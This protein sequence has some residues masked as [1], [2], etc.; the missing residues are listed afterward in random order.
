M[1]I[2]GTGEFPPQDAVWNTATKYR[3]N[4][5]YPKDITMT[6]AGVIQILRVAR[7]DWH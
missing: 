1:E 2:E 5:T 7:M 4:L 6:I 3:I